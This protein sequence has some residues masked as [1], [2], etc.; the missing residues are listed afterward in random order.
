MQD[1]FRKKGAIFALCW[2]DKGHESKENHA[3]GYD[4]AFDGI[5]KLGVQLIALHCVLQAKH[6]GQA[7]S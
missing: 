3:L 5:T 1:V 2:K 6:L 7:V 4:K